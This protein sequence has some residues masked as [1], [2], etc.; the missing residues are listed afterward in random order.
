VNNSQLEKINDVLNNGN[1]TSITGDKLIISILS[2]NNSYIEYPIS[3]SSINKHYEM[4][5]ICY[6]NKKPYFMTILLINNSE[7]SFYSRRYNHNYYKKYKNKL[8]S[9]VRSGNYFEF[10]KCLDIIATKTHKTIDYQARIATLITFILI[11]AITLFRDSC[12][13]VNNKSTNRSNVLFIDE[14]GRIHINHMDEKKTSKIWYNIQ[15]FLQPYTNKV[16]F[17]IKQF[18]YR[19][20]PYTSKYNSEICPICLCEWSS[21]S[22][23]VL[24]CYHKYHYDCLKQIK[25]QQ[26]CAICLKV[27]NIKL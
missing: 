6:N 4:M 17:N 25:K 27:H 10:V 21:E 13:N 7:F 11:L 9:S 24:P 12:F 20:H 16:C 2:K 26:T 18:Y 15:Q 19:L 1:Y 23:I 3:N 14:F 5:K 8:L 22:V